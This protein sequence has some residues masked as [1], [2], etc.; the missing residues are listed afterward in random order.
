MV[1]EKEMN[2]VAAALGISVRTVGEDDARTLLG[3][4]REKYGA[5]RPQSKPLWEQLGTVTSVQDAKAWSYVD[6]LCG[7]GSVTLLIEEG[8]VTGY[9][10][11]SGLAVREVLAELFAFEFYLT[12]TNLSFIIAFN[13]H[14]NLIVGGTATDRLPQC[15]RG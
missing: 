11:D 7:A 10:F 8:G 12:D 4:L 1:T 15:F 2:H 13:H 9:E 5:G 6:Q 14:D 3:A